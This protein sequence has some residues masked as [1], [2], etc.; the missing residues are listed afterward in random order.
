[1]FVKE[2]GIKKHGKRGGL[3]KGGDEL[4]GAVKGVI[5]LTDFSQ[6]GFEAVVVG[7]EVGK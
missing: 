5:Y 6:D 7:M 4:R 3:D 2:K 1:M